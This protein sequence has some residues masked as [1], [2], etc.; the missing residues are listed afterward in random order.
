MITRVTYRLALLAIVVLSAS[1]ALPGLSAQAATAASATT[2]ASTPGG[3]TVSTPAETVQATPGQTI[4]TTLQITNSTD[5]PIPVVMSRAV[6]TLG[7]DGDTAL[8]PGFDPNFGTITFSPSSITIAPQGWA[9]IAVTIAVP[10]HLQPDIY[11]L[12]IFVT[13]QPKAGSVQVVNRIGAIYEI[14]LPGSHDRHLSATFLPSP[15]FSFS[16][17]L[18]SVLRVRNIGK[19]AVRFTTEF[20][21]AG[22]GTATPADTRNPSLLI[23]AGRYR[24]VTVHWKT[25]DF[26]SQTITAHVAFNQTQITSIQVLDTQHHT[27]ISALLLAC[28]GALLLIVATLTIVLVRRRRA[29][30]RRNDGARHKA[31][32]AQVTPQTSGIAS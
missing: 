24:D 8:A 21:M 25:S 2:A 19:S 18:T 5:A 13:P 12:G 27:V 31:G 20:T 10:A 11:V 14:N 22:F 30:A 28:V 9:T 6:T 15:D 16:T 4:S 7:N 17:S 23:P 1:A 32:A 3:L 26:A 29:R